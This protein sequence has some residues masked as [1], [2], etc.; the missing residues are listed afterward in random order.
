MRMF[1]AAVAFL[2][3]TPS[4]ALPAD[5]GSARFS[6]IK[7]DVQINNEDT[8]EWV[9]AAIN[10][11]LSEGDRVWSPERSRTEIQIR[12]GIY[13][14]L[15]AATSL[16]VMTL[17]EQALQFYLAEGRSYV[18]NRQGGID[19]LQIDTP[20][21]SISGYDN[22]VIM[23]DVAADGRTDLAVLKGYA[24]AETATGR[25]RV[26]AG[27]ALHID[28]QSGAELSPISAPDTW[29]R[30]NQK[31]DAK[32]AEAGESLRYLPDELDDY[33]ADLNRN[34]QW[35]YVSDYGYCWTPRVGITADW[36]PYQVGRW[37]WRR[38][39]YVWISYEPWG[40]A[41]YHYGRWAYA[42][43]VGWCWVP[44]ARG[45]AYWAPG[46]VGWVD[47]GSEVAWVPLAPG[48][49][50]YG[51][52]Y[53]GPASVNISV[54][55]VTTINRSRIVYRNVSVRN[56]VTVVR[57]DDFVAGR[58][59]RPVRGRENPFHALHREERVGIAPPAVRAERRAAAPI[60]KRIP[61]ASRPPE[62]VRSHNPV[63]IREERRLRQS[64]SESGFKPQRPAVEMPVRERKEPRQPQQRPETPQRQREHRGEEPGK[65]LV[66]PT[67]P[68][69]QAAPQGPP[70]RAPQTT[71]TPPA[72]APA[73]QTQPQQRRG[74]TPPQAQP[75]SPPAQS[76]PPQEVKPEGRTQPQPQA[77]PQQQRQR[78]R[79]RPAA[80]GRQ[81]A[82]EQTAPAVQREE[83][84]APRR[85][86]EPEREPERD[87]EERRR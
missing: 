57:R 25:V 23:V 52:G 26:T 70:G 86:R 20:L 82:A 41:P 59:F 11:P 2:L 69:T 19:H 55:N 77:Q 47:T 83:R 53:Y 42:T 46:Y 66:R 40:W 81:P 62:R 18:N 3:C 49:T 30:W 32:I 1:A 85:E 17:D 44:P 80:Q 29:E 22:S 75:Q 24:Y 21:T 73:P 33:A 58:K 14:R 36:S 84:A 56:A 15:G 72:L 61:D 34:G 6:L 76:P 87:R 31:Q 8:E 60:I 64:E 74:Q 54:V 7:G 67:V 43:G 79:Q 65:R 16:D 10:M 78:Q 9:A 27:S 13:L 4:F 39:S 35:V 48:E 68:A 50:Y 37:A 71:T 12:G 28:P 45:G 5:L 63:R 38:G 51:Y